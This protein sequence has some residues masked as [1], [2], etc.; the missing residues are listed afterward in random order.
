MV[1][2]AS[3]PQKHFLEFLIQCFLDHCTHRLQLSISEISKIAM[4]LDPLNS[5]NMYR[6]QFGNLEQCLKHGFIPRV[7]YLDNNLLKVRDAKELESA[8]NESII[9]AAQKQALEQKRAE[10]YALQE[11]ARQNAYRGK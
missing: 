9:T 11:L 3:S 8:V 6:K 4:S 7:F 5:A 1:S 2:V 10:I